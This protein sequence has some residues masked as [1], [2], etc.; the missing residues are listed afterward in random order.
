MDDSCDREFAHVCKNLN[1][2]RGEVAA[3]SLR[4]TLE[5]SLIFK[6]DLFSSMLGFIS[7]DENI[8]SFY[9]DLLETST[10]PAG[11]INCI[12]AS[13]MCIDWNS[14]IPVDF[15]TSCVSTL[16]PFSGGDGQFMPIILT[17]I[18]LAILRS[19]GIRVHHNVKEIMKRNIY[20]WRFFFILP[21]EIACSKPAIWD[22]A[23]ILCFILAHSVSPG[24]PRTTILLR[25]FLSLAEYNML[26]LVL[27]SLAIF[28]LLTACISNIGLSRN[29]RNILRMEI[30]ETLNRDVV[31]LWVHGNISDLDRLS[32]HALGEV[33]LR[34]PLDCVQ[35]Q[36][37]IT[38]L[39]IL[40]TRPT[41][42][43]LLDLQRTVLETQST[44]LNELIRKLCTLQDDVRPARTSTFYLSGGIVG[45]L[46]SYIYFMYIALLACE[47]RYNF[48]VH[49]KFR[50]KF[51]IINTYY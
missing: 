18:V 35:I 19:V 47:L 28:L 39:Q 29:L 43:L 31:S 33:L 41:F 27:A 48:R 12:D 4:I 32:E 22:C 45:A 51:A 10:V 15:I 17:T 38:L 3:C 30:L 49:K 24:Y 1:D 50:I 13:L 20:G 42:S 8:G 44:G 7:T 14:V 37:K 11:A 6:S 46:I 25:I 36:D 16:L 5:R 26:A 34:M 2:M 21:I 9:S 40:R 23:G